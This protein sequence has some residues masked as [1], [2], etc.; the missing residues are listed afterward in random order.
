MKA[1]Q[2]FSHR[3]CFVGLTCNVTERGHTVPRPKTGSQGKH[4]NIAVGPEPEMDGMDG[5]KE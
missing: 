3:T 4:A 1:G 2:C 5:E